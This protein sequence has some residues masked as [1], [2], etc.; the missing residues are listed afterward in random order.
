MDDEVCYKQVITKPRAEKTQKGQSYQRGCRPYYN[1]HN[2]TVGCQRM[3]DYIDFCY[4]NTDR[5]N[6]LESESAK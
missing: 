4:C 2:H 5:C 1:G 6:T 3:N